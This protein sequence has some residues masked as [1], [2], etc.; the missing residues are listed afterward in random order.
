MRIPRCLSA[1]RSG[2]LTALSSPAIHEVRI[3]IVN[4]QH[5]ITTHDGKKCR[6][7]SRCNWQFVRSIVFT[8]LTWSVTIWR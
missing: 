5:R 7:E 2:E 6:E 1:S 8:S 4:T 3:K